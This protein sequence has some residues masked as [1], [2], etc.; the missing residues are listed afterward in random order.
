MY[1]VLNC[2]AFEH[3]PRL[4]GLSALL[5]FLSCF[6]AM[7]LLQRAR[8]ASRW[9]RVTW[10]FIAGI[11]G[12]FGIWA[13]HFS[14][15]IA[16]DTGVVVGYGLWL[17]II[18]LIIAIVTTVAAAGSSTYLTGK[19]GVLAAAILFGTG[20][21][22][23][24]FV[25]MNAVEFP[26]HFIWDEGM[27]LV[28]VTLATVFSI[29]AFYA[30]QTIGKRHL[31]VL[32]AAFFLSFAIVSMHFTGMAAITV[33]PDPTAMDVVNLLSPTV[34]ILMIVT[35]AS[36]LLICGI[37]A[38]Y[39]AARAESMVSASDKNFKLLVQGV[40]D[41]AIYM[42]DTEGRVA[43]WN[44]GAE[45]AKGYKAS[46]IVGENFSRFYSQADQQQGLPLK[47]LEEAR[48]KGK[49][50]S[51][52]WRVRKDGSRFWAHVVIDPISDDNGILI[53]FAKITRDCTE[54]KAHEE[55]LE[56]LSRNLSMAMDNMANALCLF[57]GS[58]KLVLNNQRIREIFD[59]PEDTAL[60]GRTFKELCDEH[61]Q[62]G[63]ELDDDAE[64]FYQSHRH[65]IT[66]GVGG[67]IIRTIASGK[68]IRTQH[69]PTADGSW[70]TTIEDIT[71]RVQSENQIAHLARHDPLT[72]L[73]NRRQFIEL[74]E[75]ALHDADTRTH[76]VAV[77]CID[78]DGFKDIND[79][80]GHGAGDEVL[81]TLAGRL[82]ETSRTDEMIGR[83]GGDEF[84][85]AKKFSHDDE[86]QDFVARLNRALTK[87][88]NL[89]HGDLHPGASLGV[90]VWPNDAADREKLISNADM[91]M[92]RSKESLDE[93]ISYY[94][95]SMDETARDRRAMARDIWTALD[96]NQF[97][98]N[99]QVQRSAKDQTI[100]G[101]EVLLRWKH[102]VQ[103]LISPVVFIPIA[104]ECGAIIALGD[105][106]LEQACR[107]A[108]ERGLEHKIAV[109]LSPLQL[110]NVALVDRV[111]T[112]LSETGLH[113]SMLELEVTESAIIGDKARALH[114]LR[115]IKDMGVT[116]AI[117]DFG[118]G[119]SSLET[120]RSFP[121]DKI[122]L[123]RSFINE[124]DGRQSKAFVR[125]IVAL[126][127]SLDV[128]ILAEGVET[129]HQLEVLLSEG[130][131]EVQGFLFGRPCP[132]DQISSQNCLADRTH[133]AEA[134]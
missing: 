29:P 74:L 107:Q 106:V 77:V 10:F 80:F 12:G 91:A 37:T 28:A 112:V 26:G 15:M 62:R 59:I 105:W 124:L 75:N 8:H 47:A 115:Q 78:L 130:C 11:A 129:D 134:A 20:V 34:M 66:N 94:E 85:A 18:S 48:T 7:T 122:K 16:Y 27:V 57:D 92:Y 4:V 81:C 98:L 73:S 17:T 67:E 54:R 96:D 125:A 63:I 110:M 83:F 69:R 9:Q 2:L 103:G 111:R 95:A 53:G 55:R 46:E 19:V 127:K 38:A 93:K 44:A 118:T 114:I 123:D 86:L 50:E 22:S 61:Y 42:L 88:I 41:Y 76:K 5:C 99:Y 40:T 60:I 14:A 24:H 64:G 71:A 1:R 121:F 128:S 120:L 30:L 21:S 31:P 79:T 36:A 131:D 89:Q 126:G 97:F 70:V 87:P 102:P 33:V 108:V 65:I 35:V 43:N 23:M 56:E 58:E 132:L 52:G 113:P 6:A 133:S 100:T 84:V 82:M 49:F 3:D 101:Y 32:T 109:N 13:T 68:V 104:E 119:Y 72:G 25:G 39:F 116:I 117:D 45:R 90:A 51:E